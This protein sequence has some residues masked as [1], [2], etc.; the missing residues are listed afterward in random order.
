[1][2]LPSDH[3]GYTHE[4]AFDEGFLA[5]G[6]IHQLYY[7]QYGKQDGKPVLFLHGGP[8]GQTSKSNTSYFN[9]AMYRVVLF[10][11]RGAGKSTP[12]AEIRD[13]TT[14]HILDDIEVLRK[15]LGIAKWHT[16]FGGS[17]GSTLAL[18]YAQEELDWSRRSGAARI[19]PDFFDKFINYLPEEDRENPYPAYYKLLTSEDREIRLAAA[20]RWNTWD[21]SI[22]SLLP[23]VAL[24]EKIK[25]DNWSLAH[26]VLE[27]HY[28]VHG[29]WLEEGQILKKSNIDRIRHIPTTIIQG[30][31]D[32]VC[33]P[34]TAYDLH[35]AWPESKLYWIQ[36]AGHSASEPGIR[37]KLMDVSDEYA[38]L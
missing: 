23:N 27:C 8:G 1:M 7:S 3:P 26:A 2:A 5:V 19:F 11:Q 15:Q 9:P 35:Q 31:Y 33:P 34:Q 30:R 24:L 37:N 16:V 12:N 25:D 20:R 13:N 4:D 38:Q 18:L 17:W 32:I 21:I 29:A 28:F 22:G 6:S 36:D 10:D 14:Q